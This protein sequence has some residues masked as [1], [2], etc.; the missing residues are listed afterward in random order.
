MIPVMLEERALERTRKDCLCPLPRPRGP[1][2][3]D[4]AS[5]TIPR[6][7]EFWRLTVFMLYPCR[8]QNCL[9][10]IQPIGVVA[11]FVIAARRPKRE[12]G[13]YLGKI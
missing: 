13:P 5:Q 10:G 11:H 8:L 3:L 9:Q 7:P 6:V 12:A 4:D 2:I 1:Y